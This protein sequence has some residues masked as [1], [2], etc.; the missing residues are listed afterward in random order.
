MVK[1]KFLVSYPINASSIST[2]K[3]DSKNI[4]LKIQQ[5]VAINTNYIIKW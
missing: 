2:K 5:L 4:F 3:W 1:N